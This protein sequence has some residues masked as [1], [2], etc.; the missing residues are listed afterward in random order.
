MIIVM[1]FLIEMCDYSSKYCI[2]ITTLH[3]VMHGIED[4]TE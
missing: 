2:Y 1:K 4:V 3:S